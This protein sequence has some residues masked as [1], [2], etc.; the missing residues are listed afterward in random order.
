MTAVITLIERLQL[1]ESGNSVAE[2]MRANN[3]L[4]FCLT[5]ASQILPTALDA[6]TSDSR[7]TTRVAIMNEYRTEYRNKPLPF[8][9]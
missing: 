1:D 8:I 9:L 4:Y 3:L 7:A 2:N 6:L 5:D